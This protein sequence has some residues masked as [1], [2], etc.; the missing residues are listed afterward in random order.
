MNTHST[1]A[2]NANPAAAVVAVSSHASWA[3]SGAFACHNRHA[4][5]PI[6]ATEVTTSRPNPSTVSGICAAAGRT[7]GGRASACQ[8]R[9]DSTVNAV[10]GARATSPAAV[11]ITTS[12]HRGDGKRPVGYNNG[13]S[14][15]SRNSAGSHS[16]DASDNAISRAGSPAS[17]TYA[18]IPYT[19]RNV[20]LIPHTP[21]VRRIQP[22]ALRVRS[23]TSAAPVSAYTGGMS[24]SCGCS[25]ACGTPGAPS[26][27]RASS[28]AATA[29]AQV[30]AAHP[31]AVHL[32]ARSTM[33]A[34][35]ARRCPRASTAVPADPGDPPGPTGTPDTSRPAPRRSSLRPQEKPSIHREQEMSTTTHPVQTTTA[36][37]VGF[38]AAGAATSTA[39][40]AYGTFK[41]D[42]LPGDLPTWLFINLPIIAVATVLVFTVFVRRALRHHDPEPA[43]R[44]ALVLSLLAVASVVIFN[45]GLNAVL[46]APYWPAKPRGR[47]SAKPSPRNGSRSSTRSPSTTDGGPRRLGEAGQGRRRRRAETVRTVAVQALPTLMVMKNGQVIARQA[48]AAPAAVLRAWVENALGSRP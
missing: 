22:T 38:A 5:L 24:T 10:T 28:G 13:S 17:E 18:R 12:R 37:P 39:L 41:E 8:S 36:R 32:A 23:H 26:K 4:A 45:F 47:R 6:H 15:G 46:P 7:S 35:S 14:V 3:R 1:G 25:T 44:T 19:P 42:N 30:V 21:M 27:P 43:A 48:G 31:A 29:M 33:P 40:T 9:S 20:P 34:V 11:E 16:H 2:V